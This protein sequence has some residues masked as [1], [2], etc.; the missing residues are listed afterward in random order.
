MTTV[1]D[2]LNRLNTIA[3][4]RIA[5]SW[6][7]VGLIWGDPDTRVQRVMTCLTVTPGTAREAVQDRAELIIS[8]HPVL[9]RATKTVVADDPEI[10]FLW[11]LARSGVSILS[12]HTAFDN[13]AGGI[14]DILADRLGLVEVRAL[15]PFSPARCFTT[16]DW[17]IRSAITSPQ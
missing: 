13:A 8:H 4:L 12:P 15:R 2:V 3:P 6:D 9:F 1:R 5:E 14:N 10:G 11:S 16:C 17:V 7:N